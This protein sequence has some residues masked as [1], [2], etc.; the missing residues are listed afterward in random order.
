MAN[1]IL[2]IN[3]GTTSTKIAIYDG[4]QHIWSE[5]IDHNASDL[6]AFDSVAAQVEFRYEHVS[7]SIP[8]E[9]RNGWSAVV[10]R[11]GLLR[12]LEGGTYA[13]S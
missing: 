3:P 9:L 1:T 8:A 6:H 2:V 4:A 5:A 7:S 12:P 11:G 13:V 10:G